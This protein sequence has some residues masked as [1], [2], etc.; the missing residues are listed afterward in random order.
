ME[1]RA[2]VFVDIGDPGAPL[3]KPIR[4]ALSDIVN[5]KVPGKNFHTRFDPE[6]Y[7]RDQKT[8]LDNELEQISG[9]VK[10]YASDFLQG[11]FSLTQALGEYIHQQRAND[12]FSRE[13]ARPS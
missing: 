13:N 5:F 10:A 6:A 12:P 8:Y 9:Y 1:D 2:Q 4:F 7:S 3:W 11:D